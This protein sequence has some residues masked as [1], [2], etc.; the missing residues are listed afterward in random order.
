MD[1]YSEKLTAMIDEAKINTLT[2]MTMEVPCCSGLLHMAKEAAD[3][4]ERKIPIKSMVIGL[5][6][7]I[8]SEEWV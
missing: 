7:A 6:G 1:V 2:V 5:Q 4:A 3:K 8:I